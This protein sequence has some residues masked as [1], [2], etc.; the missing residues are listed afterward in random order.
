MSPAALAPWLAERYGLTLSGS[1]CI[2]RLDCEIHR[3]RCAGA[4]HD[5][6][7]RIYPPRVSDRT[8]IEDEVTWLSA[9]AAHGLHVPGPLPGLDGVLIQAWVDGR[10]AVLLSWVTGRVLDKAL[11]PV[12]LWR[13]GRLAGT[14]HAVSGAL[15][16]QGRIRGKRLGDGPD[17]AAWAEGRRT[18]HPALPAKA[19]RHIEGA[20]RRLQDE[21]ATLPRDTAAWGFIH[22]D[23]HPWNLLF[24]GSVAG[25]IDFSECGYG[26][27]A[28]DLAAALQYLKHPVVGNHDHRPAYPRLQAALLDGYATVR[29]LP[30]HVDWQIDRLIELRMINTI[31]WV[32]YVW[33]RIDSR[34]WGPAFLSGAAELVGDA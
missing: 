14:M 28:L 9:L 3:L 18:A 5:L 19:W 22:S 8:A 4:A 13:V 25:A 24:Q 15:V 32:L 7:L 12:H 17:L 27:F 26:P 21:M 29:P 1:R 6:A 20:A 23:L 33:P 2:A 10:W 34:P 31:E 16:A 11:K 30:A